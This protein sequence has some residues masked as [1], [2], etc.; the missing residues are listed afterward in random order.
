MMH[1]FL[2]EFFC[3]RRLVKSNPYLVTIES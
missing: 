2:T 1:E 3:V